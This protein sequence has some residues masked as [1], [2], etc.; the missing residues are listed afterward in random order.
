MILSSKFI[1]QNF[2]FEIPAKM[3]LTKFDIKHLIRTLHNVKLEEDNLDKLVDAVTTSPF[4]LPFLLRN[5]ASTF[6]LFL[7]SQLKDPQKNEPEFQT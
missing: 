6:F 7:I 2:K 4:K 1:H 3:C 5:H